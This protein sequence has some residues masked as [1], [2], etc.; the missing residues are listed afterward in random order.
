MYLP[1]PKRC[2]VS[3][4]QKE[5]KAPKTHRK[6]ILLVNSLVVLARKHIAEMTNTSIVH[7]RNFSPTAFLTI[8]SDDITHNL[9]ISTAF[10]CHLD[11]M[12]SILV[13]T[14]L[15]IW[16]ELQQIQHSNRTIMFLEKLL[17]EFQHIRRQLQ[18]L[19]RIRHFG[20]IERACQSSKRSFFDESCI[21]LWIG[22]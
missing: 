7:N 2:Q 3:H 15:P 21:L 5:T 11:E 17:H 13:V 19:T 1:K 10:P 20:I 8:S 22:R 12:L 18:L 4:D 16:F 6:P 9:S 14:L